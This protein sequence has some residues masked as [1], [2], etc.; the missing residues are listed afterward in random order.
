MTD[1]NVGL[2]IVEDEPGTSCITSNRHI[3]IP[4]PMNE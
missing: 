1:K 4:S 3:I 2:L